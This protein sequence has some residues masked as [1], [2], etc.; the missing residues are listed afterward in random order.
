MRNTFL[1]FSFV[2]IG[3]GSVAGIALAL[4]A[5]AVRASGPWYVTVGGDD[6]ND[7]LS[8]DT[9]CANVDS[10]L[11]KPGFTP[12]DTIRVAMGTYTADGDQ[13]VR[14]SKSVVLSGGW[15]EGF[16]AEVGTSILDGEDLRRGVAVSSG[17]TATVERFTVQHARGQF[18]FAGYG[19]GGGIYNE[20]TLVLVSSTVTNSA[21]F[22]GGGGL[23]SS[24][25]AVLADSTIISNTAP[26]D[27]GGGVYNTGVLKLIHSGVLS[28]AARAGGG[29]WNEGILEVAT[30]QVVANRDQGSG[31]G[32]FSSGSLTVTNST[33]FGNSTVGGG[34]AIMTAGTLTIVG[35]TIANNTSTM[36]AGGIL[37]NGGTVEIINSTLSGNTAPLSGGA[38]VNFG[39]MILSN[40]TVVSNT[41]PGKTLGSGVYNGYLLTLTN[42]IMSNDLAAGPNCYIYAGQVNSGGHNLSNDA[43]CALTAA[44]DLSNTNPSLGPLQA[45]G[46]P[47]WTNLPLPASPALNAADNARC[48]ATDQRG[49]VRPQGGACDIGTVEVGA[50]PGLSG[51]TPDAA[52]AAGPGFTLDVYG[53][54]FIDGSIVLW[55]HAPRRTTFVSGGQLKAVIPAADIALP[56]TVS[57]SVQ[58]DAPDGGESNGLKFTVKALLYLPLVER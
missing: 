50:V 7:C 55:N 22:Y 56:V 9:A 14:L 46:G 30:S 20:G 16:V 2:L 47:T 35:S 17:V 31:A 52:A 11:N 41:A 26:Q 43:T 29:I 39:S 48:A 44:G 33:L 12:G 1:T 25:T 3:L 34:G 54:N 19:Y 4:A 42:S 8:P 6:R 53:S 13:V 58:P 32:I 15:D 45:N 10:V 23:Y 36:N 49:I 5:P 38:I 51:L 21:A 24:G 18:Q 28:N 40:S 37:V 27:N 57:V